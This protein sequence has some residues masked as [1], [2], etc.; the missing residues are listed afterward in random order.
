[1][2]GPMTAA[3]IGAPVVRVDVAFDAVCPWCYI[4]IRRLHQVIALRPSVS[5]A[6]NWRPFLLNP[7]MPPN[8]IDRRLYL[9]RKFGGGQRMQRV[10][11]AVRGA[12]RSVGI[13]FAFER[14]DRTPS[15][16]EC[17]R[18]IRFA[19]ASERSAVVETLFHA[20]FVDGRDIGEH[21]VL[22]DIAG[23]LGLD[24]DALA[25]Y[26]DTNA[27]IQAI[28]AESGR[29]HR[30]GISGVPC[31]VFNE[32]FAI[33]GAQDSEVLL[34]LLDLAA[35]SAVALPVSAANG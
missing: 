33:A 25:A 8:G 26:L 16:V 7:G 13:P 21:S 20:Y 4:G 18:L 17:H 24:I 34:R 14:I 1:M 10:F 9:E 29:A 32:S 28:F 2:H 30:L 23:G 6:I 11:G 19:A 12:G 15:T 5:V 22:L 35:E 27:D 31:Y 3:A